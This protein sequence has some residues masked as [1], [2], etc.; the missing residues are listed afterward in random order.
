MKRVCYRSNE[1]F[2]F[3]HGLFGIHIGSIKYVC[4]NCN[5]SAWEEILIRGRSQ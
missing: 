2:E 1:V 4:P 5:L 3:S